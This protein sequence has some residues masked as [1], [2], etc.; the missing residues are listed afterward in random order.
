MDPHMRFIP[1][2]LLRNSYIKYADSIN[3]NA[4]PY[5]TIN[6]DLELG[7][8]DTKNNIDVAKAVS[9]LLTRSVDDA[10]A[11][12]K[13]NVV[14][15]K[16]IYNGYLPEKIV[17]R[18]QF[19]Y[20][21]P[22]AISNLWGKFGYRFVL[23]RKV[24]DYNRRELI[25]TALISS[26]KDI[27]FFFT[28]KYNN[29]RYSRINQFVDFNLLADGKN[30]WFDKFDMPDAKDYKPVDCNQLANFAVE[31]I[32]CRG[33]GLGKLLITEIIKNYAINYPF[34]KINHSQPLICGKG[35]F[36]IA[37]PSWIDFMID[38]GFKLRLGAETFYIDRDWDP[39]VPI[40]I[41]DKKMD[42]IEYN[43]MFNMP[44]IYDS[45]KNINSHDP[46]LHRINHVSKL[47]RSGDAKLQ[48]FQLTYMFN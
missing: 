14:R 16:N 48:Y 6:D 22:H 28:S 27:L 1:T 12:G 10:K 11:E 42:N 26:S 32:G 3:Y 21:S 2:D 38:I 17:E 7:I 33:L 46:L 44:K 5:V 13:K 29:V 43:S 20:V 23:T 45:L 18:A 35:L 30:K 15:G 47:A 41:N 37:D 31:K 25:G 9:S 39:L 19:E 36:Q 4:K 8:V 40:I 24:G 34:S